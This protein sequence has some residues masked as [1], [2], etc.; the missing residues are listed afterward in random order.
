MRGDNEVQS[1]YN[2]EKST[3]DNV[4]QC[5]WNKQTHT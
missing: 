3:G 2:K 1:D 5:D 4:L